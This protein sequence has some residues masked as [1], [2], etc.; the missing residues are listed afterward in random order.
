M[1]YMKRVELHSGLGA[2]PAIRAMLQPGQ[3]VSASGAKG[4]WCGQTKS[5]V[6]VVAW[7]G[8]ATGRPGGR[9]DYWRT[10][11]AYAAGRA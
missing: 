5:G 6:D 3:Y 8:N 1:R 11:R 10:L 4:R 2:E 9:M 7:E